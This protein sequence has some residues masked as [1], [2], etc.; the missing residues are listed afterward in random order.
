MTVRNYEEIYAPLHENYVK[1]FPGRLGRESAV[2][3]ASLVEQ[4]GAT[5][6]LDYGCGKGYQYLAKRVHERWGNILPYCYD[7]GVR[8][9]RQKPEGRFDGIICTDVLEHID[10]RDLGEVL[11]DIFSFAAETS[12]VYLEI[13]CRPASK[14]FPPDKDHPYGENIHLTVKRPEWWRKIISK[15]KRDGLIIADYYEWVD[16]AGNASGS[17]NDVQQAIFQGLRK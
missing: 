11:T 8:Q 13:C 1:W 7:P 12:F 3:I 5:R 16:N 17:G 4:V 10:K 9:L 15:H 6:L 2:R 14:V